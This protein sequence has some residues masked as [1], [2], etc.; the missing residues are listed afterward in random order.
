MTRGRL[1]ID[2]VRFTQD[3]ASPHPTLSPNVPIGD[4]ASKTGPTARA[5]R[6]PDGNPNDRHGM[7]TEGL[8]PSS[9]SVLVIYSL[10]LASL[11]IVQALDRLLDLPG[12]A[13][14][15]F[16]CGVSVLI[17]FA[18]ALLMSASPKKRLAK[19][20][21]AGRQIVLGGFILVAVAALLQA[22]A[23]FSSSPGE[24]NSSGTSSFHLLPA[25][26]P[27]ATP[28]PTKHEKKKLKKEKAVSATPSPAGAAK[29]Q[30]PAPP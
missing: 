29:P 11:S 13:Y 10:I 15:I 30:A 6:V 9:P 1:A 19:A 28:P 4:S 12:S 18:A 8:R 16:L 27:K 5:T 21:G 14:Y 25:Y 24:E 2:K 17:L 23:A 20:A 7:K 26:T 22:A 3:P